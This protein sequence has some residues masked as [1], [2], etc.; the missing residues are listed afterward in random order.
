MGMQPEDICEQLMTKC[1]APDIQMGGLGG[2]NMTVVLICFLHKQPYSTLI[3]K[4]ASSL[5]I[6]NADDSGIILSPSALLEASKF[7]EKELKEEQNDAD[8]KEIKED[9]LVFQS[10]DEVIEDDDDDDED[11][12][13]IHNE[14]VE[15]VEA[16]VASAEK[17]S[18]EPTTTNSNNISS[19]SNNSS[20]KSNTINQISDNV[21]NSTE[22]N[23][24]TQTANN[25]PKT[26]DE[27]DLK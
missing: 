17:S 18:I 22:T 3:E 26:T 13:K 9:N 15:D 19:S 4:C 16:K 14:I 21:V 6:R 11:E 24:E 23:T 27:I 25:H 8:E 10:H 1:L 5:E 7:E 12:V 20:N 2:D